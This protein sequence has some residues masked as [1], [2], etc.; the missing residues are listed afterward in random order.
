MLINNKFCGQIA[1]ITTV[2]T[3][4]PPLLITRN[5]AFSLLFAY[6]VHFP[7]PKQTFFFKLHPGLK[8]DLYH[9]LC[10]YRYLIALPSKAVG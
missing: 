2:T 4:I 9:Y 6:R 7:S 1:Q 5:N 8:P 10:L 3:P